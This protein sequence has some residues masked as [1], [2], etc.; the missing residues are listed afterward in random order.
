MLKVD[1][2]AQIEELSLKFCIIFL[3]FCFDLFGKLSDYY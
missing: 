3:S 1:T 2:Y